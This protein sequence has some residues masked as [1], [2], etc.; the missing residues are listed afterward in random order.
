MALYTKT[1]DTGT[2]ALIGGQRVPKYDPRVEAYGTVDE[3]GAHTALLCD[4]LH[5]RTADSEFI[6]PLRE[7]GR[8]LMSVQAILA[9]GEN[10]ANKIADISEQHIEALERQIDSMSAALPPISNF[11]IPGGDTLLSQCHV[12]RTVCR[13]AERRA[14]EAA[15]QFSMPAAGAIRYL[16]RLSD[17]LYIFGRTV[18]KT[19]GVQEILWQP[20]QKF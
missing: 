2:T 14:V 1:G 13:R 9:T 11:T 17:W 12:C 16:N 7:I 3:L 15:A 6:A 5:E 19:Y 20:P 10:A 4:M 8:M 18:V